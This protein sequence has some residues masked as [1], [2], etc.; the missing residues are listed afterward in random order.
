MRMFMPLPIMLSS[1]VAFAQTEELRFPASEAVVARDVGTQGN[2]AHGNL[3]D[4]G[5]QIGWT[6]PEGFPAGVYRALI[7]GRTGSSGEGTSFVAGYRLTVPNRAFA[8]G[9]EPREIPL[10]WPGVA[11]PTVRSTGP[12]YSVFQGEAPSAYGVLEL[13]Q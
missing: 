10:Y 8:A 12:G 1:A 4:P 11:R 6:L 5:D 2:V 7:D 9:A 13:A 3:P